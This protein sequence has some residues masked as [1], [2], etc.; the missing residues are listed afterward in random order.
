MQPMYCSRDYNFSSRFNQQYEKSTPNA[1]AHLLRTNDW[2]DT[3]RLQED[4]KVQ[5]FCLTLTR[6]A[7]F[8]YESLRLINADWAGLQKS[9]RQQ[10]SKVG[11]TRE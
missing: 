11:N 5:R 4:D 3:H 2:M 10:Y 1:E 6:E 7:R 8:W 9:F